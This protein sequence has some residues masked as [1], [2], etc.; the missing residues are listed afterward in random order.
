MPFWCLKFTSNRCDSQASVTI[1]IIPIGAFW[2]INPFQISNWCVARMRILFPEVSDIADCFSRL[3]IKH[4]ST[5]QLEKYFIY[6]FHFY[7]NNN[8]LL[9]IFYIKFG[10]SEH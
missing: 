4:F 7:L 1:R 10:D 9:T 2:V 6:L 8:L 3:N 5:G